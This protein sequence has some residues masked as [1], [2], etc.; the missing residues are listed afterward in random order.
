MR[1]DKGMSN[2][3]GDQDGKNRRTRVR[4]SFQKAGMKQVRASKQASPGQWR[5]ASQRSVDGREPSDDCAYVF[6][7]RT[8]ILET[9]SR[10]SKLPRCA[11]LPGAGHASYNRD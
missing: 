5:P 8:W 3:R 1:I 2:V 10:D 4:Q 7:H 6:A 9:I 11:I